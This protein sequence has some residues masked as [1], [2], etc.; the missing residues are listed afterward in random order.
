MKVA[1]EFASEAF[2]AF[3]AVGRS[4]YGIVWVL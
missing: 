1:G 3:E 2:E 4:E